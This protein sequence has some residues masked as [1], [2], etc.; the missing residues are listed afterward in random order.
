MDHPPLPQHRPRPSNLRKR[1]PCQSGQT[2]TGIFSLHPQIVG[3]FS[4]PPPPPL[5]STCSTCSPNKPAKSSPPLAI[6][7]HNEHRSAFY[8][9]FLGCPPPSRP[10]DTLSL[11]YIQTL[12][13][14][15]LAEHIRVSAMR[16]PRL[17]AI[18]LQIFSLEQTPS[19]NFSNPISAS[20]AACQY[21]LQTAGSHKSTLSSNKMPTPCSP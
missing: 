7:P 21:P 18:Q 19:T 8:F 20:N 11:L 13:A 10:Y 14:V 9:N 2:T 3:Q 16:Y 5:F 12:H 1:R 15:A 4:S 17:L 6:Q